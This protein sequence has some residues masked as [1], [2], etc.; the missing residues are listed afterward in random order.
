MYARTCLCVCLHVDVLLRVAK[1]PP[2]DR[3]ISALL[4]PTCLWAGHRALGVTE[5][6]FARLFTVC[7]QCV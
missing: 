3:G 1:T 5:L 4:C 6:Q 2:K 7:V